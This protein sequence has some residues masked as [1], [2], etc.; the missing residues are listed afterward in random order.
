[1]ALVTL[2]NTSSFQLDNKLYSELRKMIQMWEIFIL[3]KKPKKYIACTMAN[4]ETACARV[5]VSVSISIN[6]LPN[7]M[8][9]IS[10]M[11]TNVVMEQELLSTI[12]PR[13]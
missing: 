4:L 12:D 7:C 10:I 11:V 6:I 8:S 2:T 5:S 3:K 9:D 1:M 13:K